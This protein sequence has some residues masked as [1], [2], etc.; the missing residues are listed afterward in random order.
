MVT[1][2]TPSDLRVHWRVLRAA[3]RQVDDLISIH[4]NVMHGMPVITGTRIPVVAIW[5]MLADGYTVKDIHEEFP[6]LANEQIQAASCL[7][8]PRRGIG[9][10]EERV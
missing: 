5:G 10:G 1:T 3:T 7:P 6:H 9:E 8:I 2:I 4:P